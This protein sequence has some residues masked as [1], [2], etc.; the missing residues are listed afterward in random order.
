MHYARL[1]PRSAA[2]IAPTTT[3]KKRM[4]YFDSDDEDGPAPVPTTHDL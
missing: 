2:H 4:R 1:Q 3:P